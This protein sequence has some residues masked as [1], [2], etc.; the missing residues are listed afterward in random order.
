MAELF[1]QVYGERPRFHIYF[2]NK[3]FL[4]YFCC[5]NV[6]II[7]SECCSSVNPFVLFH[8]FE[9]K[10]DNFFKKWGGSLRIGPIIFGEAKRKGG[11][12]IISR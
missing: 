3:A 6:S 5:L 8:F 1:C 4:E 2:Q 10:K 9:M 11:W 7:T 12:K